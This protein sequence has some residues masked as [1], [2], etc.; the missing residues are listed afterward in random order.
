MT[1][2]S[3]RNHNLIIS[4]HVNCRPTGWLRGQHT[5]AAVSGFPIGRL[6]I[7]CVGYFD[8]LVCILECQRWSEKGSQYLIT[9]A[10]GSKPRRGDGNC[11][12]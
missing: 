3:C 5:R 10:S 12:V 7:V 4:I 8:P 2:P 11:G 1:Y 6:T 9:I